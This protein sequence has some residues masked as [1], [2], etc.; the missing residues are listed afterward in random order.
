MH[1]EELIRTETSAKCGPPLIALGDANE[2]IGAVEVDFG[3][4]TGGAE[5]IE[6]IRN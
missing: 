3:E 2:I 6:E 4:G 5:A 1:N